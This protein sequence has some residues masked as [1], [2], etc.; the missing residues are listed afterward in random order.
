MYGTAAPRPTTMD[1][2]DVLLVSLVSATTL[3]ASAVAVMVA[4]PLVAVQLPVMATVTVAPAAMDGGAG[5]ERGAAH[6]QPGDRGRAGRGGAPVVDRDG[7][8]D[9]RPDGRV[10]RVGGD[11]E[12]LQVGSGR[13][14]DH[15]RRRRREAVVAVFCS[16]TVLVGST[17]AE[18]V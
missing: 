10:R 9:R 13:L 4:P 12:H 1:W 7:E 3:V 5:V 15:Q 2:R 6:R 16:M 11:A 17:T 14:G 8:G 18:T